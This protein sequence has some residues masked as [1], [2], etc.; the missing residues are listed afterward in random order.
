MHFLQCSAGER[1]GL[2]VLSIAIA[3]VIGAR[4]LLPLLPPPDLPPADAESSREFEA[5]KARQQYLADSMEAVWAARRESRDKR[6][7]SSFRNYGNYRQKQGRLPSYGKAE[8][9]PSQEGPPLPHT[10]EKKA[11]QASMALLPINTADTLDWRSLPGI[12][13]KTAREIVMYRERLGGFVRCEQLMEIHWIDSARYA[14]ILP[15]LLADTATPPRRLC[16]NT[17]SIAELKQHPYID[18]YL[19]KSMVVHREKAGRYRSLEEVRAATR[20]YPELFAKL[21][22]YLSVD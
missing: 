11:K 3:L 13:A 7:N 2:I 21:K 9:R 8:V 6:K 4:M 12:G 10:Q 19:A 22:P 1:R 17:A 18:Y 5:F 14:R 15:F 20:M 16:V